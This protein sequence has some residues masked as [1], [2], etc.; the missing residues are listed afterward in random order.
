MRKEITFL[1]R[2]RKVQLGDIAPT[3]TLLDY[4]PK[5][6]WAGWRWIKFLVDLEKPVRVI[7]VGHEDCSWYRDLRFL[8]R[9]KSTRERIVDDLTAVAREVSERFP[10]VRVETYYAAL[11]GGNAVF[12]TVT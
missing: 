11:A 10:L 1:R 6:S 2:G 4:L 3:L 5:F 9:R 8:P 12:E 7:L